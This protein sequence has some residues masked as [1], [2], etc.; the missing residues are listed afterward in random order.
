MK[1]TFVICLLFRV[2]VAAA[3]GYSTTAGTV[4]FSGEKPFQSV[5]AY[6]EQVTS[7]L[8]PTTGHVEFHLIVRDFHFKKAAMEKSFNEDY[9]ESDQYPTAQF[10]GKINNINTVNFQ[11]P[12][13]Y[14]V[15]VEGNLTVH[16]VT[17]KVT[18]PGVL[19][20]TTTGIKAQSHFVVKMEDFNIAP[21]TFLGR[22]MTDVIN[23][24]VNMKY[25]VS[26]D[27]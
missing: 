16:N 19:N 4:E 13:K 1:L 14:P 7:M 10:F 25:V 3:Q 11:V 8:D 5:K 22:T 20:V 2:L 18:H 6:N 17:R 26:S 23:I 9:M 12:G 27:R 24:A 21:P 15:T